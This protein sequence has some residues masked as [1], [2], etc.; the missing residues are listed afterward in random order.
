MGSKFVGANK[1][2]KPAKHGAVSAAKPGG[3]MKSEEAGEYGRGGKK[4]C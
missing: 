4:M 3:K 2:H 1:T